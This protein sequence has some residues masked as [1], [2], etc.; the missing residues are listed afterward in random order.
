VV[1]GV[2]HL[3]AGGGVLLVHRVPICRRRVV[4]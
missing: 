1:A 4:G 3:A 2:G